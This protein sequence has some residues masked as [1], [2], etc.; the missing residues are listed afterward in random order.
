MENHPPPAPRRPRPLPLGPPP[1]AIPPAQ[2]WMQ[3][4]A[5]QQLAVRRTLLTICRHLVVAAP[6]PE[7]PHDQL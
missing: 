7:V 3:L 5:P 4:T 6:P 2:V 1:P